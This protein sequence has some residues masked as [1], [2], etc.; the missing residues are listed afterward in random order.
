MPKINNKKNPIIVYWSPEATIEKEHQQVLL[1]I[2]LRSLM[3]DI[4]KRRAINPISPK[5]AQSFQFGTGYNLCSAL[6]ELADNTYIIKAPF[7]ADIVLDETGSVMQQG[8]KFDW[9]YD[10]T[11]SIENGF[12]VDFDLSYFF[13]CEEPLEVSITPP[14]MH[15]TNQ[16]NYGFI[17]SVKW[18]ISSWFRGF[19]LIYQLWPNKKNVYFN[20]DEPIAYL[21]FDTDRKVIFKEFKLNQEILNIANS[22]GNYKFILN[23]EP[24]QK[25]YKIF[26]GTSM[27]KRLVEQIKN[28]LI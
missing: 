1:D 2:E 9:F 27:K 14:Y 22:C 25:L 17:S 3:A 20:K 6:H 24:M 21:H 28:N 5:N 15:Q 4:Q 16:P 19:V 26:N 10:R 23:F 12:C 7:D 8:K 11:T 18:D 13:F